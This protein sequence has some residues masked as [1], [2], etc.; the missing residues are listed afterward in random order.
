MCVEQ[1]GRSMVWLM[2]DAFGF[3]GHRHVLKSISVASPAWE[4]VGLLGLDKK[5]II[6][7]MSAAAGGRVGGLLSH[8]EDIHIHRLEMMARPETSSFGSAVHMRRRHAVASLK[9][10][11]VPERAATLHA[12]QGD[13][14]E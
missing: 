4:G 9:D 6:E 1:T 3:R 10:H 14:V 2:K 12:S 7:G 5:Q 11:S 13:F 8:H